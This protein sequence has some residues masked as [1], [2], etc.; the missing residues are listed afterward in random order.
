[1]PIQAPQPNLAH[2]AKDTRPTAL[3]EETDMTLA[4]APARPTVS[5]IRGL[6]TVNVDIAAAFVGISRNAYFA[7]VKSGAAPGLR[8]GRRVLVPVHA[9]LKLVGADEASS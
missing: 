4:I 3:P 7:A 5:D 9:L 8:L 2:R 6:G 1:M